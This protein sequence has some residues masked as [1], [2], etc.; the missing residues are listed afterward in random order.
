MSTLFEIWDRLAIN[1]ESGDGFVRLRLPEVQAAATYAAKSVSEGLEAVVLEVKTHAITARSDYPEAHGFSVHADMLAPGRH[2][3]TRLMVK[4][5]DGR[6]RD[7]FHTLAEDVVTKLSEVRTEEEAVNLFITRLARWQSF[8]RKHSIS[9]LAHEARRG[10]LGELLLLRDHLLSRCDHDT[11]I[12]SWK[13]SSGANHDFQFPSGSIEVKTTSSNT[14]HAFHVSSIRQL[15]S[16]G[17]GQ[18]FLYF[19][20]IEESEA[21]YLSLPQLID[22]IR[23]GLDSTALDSFEESLVE[24]GYLETQREMYSSPCYSI[25]RE[26][27][28][29][30]N[31]S[32]P[33][34]REGS[35][36]SGVEDVRYQVAIAACADFETVS[37][38]VMEFVLGPRGDAL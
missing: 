5:T 31:E 28:F 33:R 37:A 21:G 10:L 13:G 24:A 22:S 3:R 11:A 9:G 30:V 27:F 26:R 12:E 18:L 36:P 38:E 35:L 14:P 23:D 16:P 6:Y 2:G 19:L 29:R 1:G 8:M 17:Q 32:F 25:R 34:L 20:V 7:I 4:L 15:D